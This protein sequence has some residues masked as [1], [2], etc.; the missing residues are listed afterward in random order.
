MSR[1]GKLPVAI[2]E[3]VE[4]D[5]QGTTVKVKGPKG[6]LEWTFAPE[7]IIEKV[8]NQV[9]VKIDS[10]EKRVRS[11]FGTTRSLIQNMVTGVHDGFQKIIEVRGV[12]YRAEMNGD[13][14]VLHV[15]YSHPVEMTPPQGIS[16]EVDSKVPRA[17]GADGLNCYVHVNGIDKALVGQIASDVRKVRPPNVYKGKGLRYK[18]EYVKLLPGKA[19]KVG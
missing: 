13:N 11:L 5:V 7:M 9:I 6:Q 10:D 12:G 8:D 15:G 16:F 2:P 3:K 4:V 1:I 19:G 17:S 18:G 14:L